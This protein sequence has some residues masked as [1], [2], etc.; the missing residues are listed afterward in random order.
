MYAST[1]KLS[2]ALAIAISLGS[3][4]ALAAEPAATE[5]ARQ[6]VVNARQESQIWTSYALSPYLRAH[7]LH[8]TVD[9]GQATLSGKVAEDVNK[10]LAE[11]IALGVNGIKG[12]D[13][14]IVV[15]AD[16][17][18]PARG[19]ERSFGDV[20]DDASITAGIKSKL[21]WNKHLN[22]MMIDVDTTYGKV[23]L[24]GSVSD[25]AARGMAGTLA[26][27]TQGVRSVDNQLV[28]DV[29]KGETT[30]AQEVADGWIT[31]KIKST[32]MY[33]SNVDGSD[34][35]VSTS[36]GMVILK[37]TMSSGPER[38]L[39]IELATNVRG[40]KNVDATGLVL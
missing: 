30:V 20:V 16:Y 4:A 33:S 10:N 13:N 9:N 8:V 39:A 14:Q 22:A 32:Y 29:D 17:D 1:R 37:G 25:A 21:M 2:L 11:Q 6:E 3:F 36:D 28:I 38:A 27:N 35:A 31:M 12:V 26:R 15:A 40:V 23:K 5:T 18:P 34:I 24:K 7:D 19:A